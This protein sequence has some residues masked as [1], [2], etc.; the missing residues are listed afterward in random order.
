M[1]VYYPRLILHLVNS[2]ASLMELVNMKVIIPELLSNPQVQKFS[3][4][5]AILSKF[6]TVLLILPSVM[7]YHDHGG[8]VV[9]VL[10]ISI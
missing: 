7:I 1:G 3:V 2:K 4:F 9:L 10:M 8:V 6:V 5:M